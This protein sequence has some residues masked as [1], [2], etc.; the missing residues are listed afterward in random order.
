MANR[1]GYNDIRNDNWYSRLV[2]QAGEGAMRNIQATGSE[3]DDPYFT[4]KRAQAVTDI[5]NARQEAFRGDG[6]LSAY[7]A[8]NAR[9]NAAEA[10]RQ[11]AISAAL[12]RDWKP[13]QLL[14]TEA[15]GG[16]DLPASPDIQPSG[17]MSGPGPAPVAYAAPMSGTPRAQVSGGTFRP[18]K[19]Y[20][21]GQFSNPLLDR[22]KRG[23]DSFYISLTKNPVY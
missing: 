23:L 13:D 8:N 6:S 11:R 16:A 19:A 10:A 22:R 18:I 15:A 3:A 2:A 5:N 14:G 21:P 1:Y 9:M 20:D 17:L 12:A 4:L 7:A